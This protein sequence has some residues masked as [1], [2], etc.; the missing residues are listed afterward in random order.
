MK[1]SVTPVCFHD[2]FTD[3]G[4]T[5]AGRHLIVSPD[6]VWVDGSQVIHRDRRA[7]RNREPGH[8]WL[9]EGHP[10]TSFRI[11]VEDA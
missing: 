11:T 10:W 7:I 8:P 2:G 4:D 9:A 6:G 3:R 1:V 5:V